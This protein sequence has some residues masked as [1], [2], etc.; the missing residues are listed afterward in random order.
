M[1]DSP[2]PCW[3]P[4]KN[5]SSTRPCPQLSQLAPWRWFGRPWLLHA[6]ISPRRKDQSTLLVVGHRAKSR[7]MV[8]QDRGRCGHAE[9]FSPSKGT[10]MII[11]IYIYKLI[12]LPIYLSIFI[13][14]YIIL[15][16]DT[17]QNDI[18]WYRLMY[19]VRWWYIIERNLW[20][21]MAQIC[22][23]VSRLVI[24]YRIILWSTIAI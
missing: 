24:E 3:N 2:W 13:V 6:L 23:N 18:L 20:P 19:D 16:T 1:A 21:C 11:Y 17:M 8:P 7:A 15:S 14:Y 9:H 10:T 4:K 22:P 12:Y 5:R